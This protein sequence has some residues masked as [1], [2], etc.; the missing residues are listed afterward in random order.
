LDKQD[1]ELVA[2]ACGRDP[3]GK[4]RFLG[5]GNLENGPIVGNHIEHKALDPTR[6][7]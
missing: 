7:E 5:N 6:Q 2:F 4:R 1:F 3:D